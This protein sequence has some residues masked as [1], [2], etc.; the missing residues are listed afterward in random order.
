M[1]NLPK[2]DNENT[3]ETSTNNKDINSYRKNNN[4]QNIKNS[5]P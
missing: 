5:I 2:K 4:K 3:S 1:T